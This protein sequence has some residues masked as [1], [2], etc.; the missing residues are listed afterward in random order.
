MYP[1]VIDK[2]VFNKA[3]ELLKKNKYFAKSDAPRIP[4]F[5]TSKL[6]CGHCGTPMIADGGVGKLGTA[7]QYYV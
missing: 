6:F 4:Y 7:Y 3:Q 5:L 1:A 2:N